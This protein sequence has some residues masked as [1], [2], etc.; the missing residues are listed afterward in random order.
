MKFYFYSFYTQSY[1]LLNVLCNKV[2]I[3]M[4]HV[5]LHFKMQNFQH[6]KG[7]SKLDDIHVFEGEKQRE[8][9]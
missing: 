4:I 3:Y 5:C 7:F 2:D 9:I 8:I 6:L 1:L